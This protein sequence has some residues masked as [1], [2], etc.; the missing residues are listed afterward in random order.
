MDLCFLELFFK[1][2]VLHNISEFYG[3]HHFLWYFTSALPTILGPY[4]VGFLMGIFGTKNRKLL[5][6]AIWYLLVFSLLK[7]K[8][9]RFAL[10]VLPIFLLIVGEFY[11]NLYYNYSKNY[12]RL[13]IW[14]TILFNLAF[15]IYFSQFHQRGTME[16]MYYIQKN[17]S[18]TSAHFLM[19]CHSTPYYSHVHRNISMKFLEC[20]PNYNNL[21][22]HLTE[23]DKFYLNPLSFLQQYYL[24]TALP[25]HLFI[26]DTMLPQIRTFLSEKKLLSMRLFFFTLISQYHLAKGRLF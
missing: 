16:A 5:F 11:H 25:S 19:P 4:I 12:I 22:N 6:L 21:T 10:P 9:L 17:E 13:F 2:N 8:E 3:T 7:H 15:W 26:F 20:D 18:V 1:F 23:T 14:M 24:N